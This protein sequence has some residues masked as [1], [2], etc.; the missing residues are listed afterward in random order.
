MAKL[1]FSLGGEVIVSKADGLSY[2]NFQ[3]VVEK[4][5]VKKSTDF[6]GRGKGYEEN[7][8]LSGI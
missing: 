6:L 2:L 8:S 4:Q 5:K 1:A 7:N 3:S